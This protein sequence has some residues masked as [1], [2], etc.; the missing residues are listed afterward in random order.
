VDT[1][2]E[3]NPSA[4]T[5]NVHVSVSG[6][7]RLNV[8]VVDATGRI[9]RHLLDGPHP[10][11][12]YSLTWDGRDDESRELPAGVYFTHVVTAKGTTTGRVVLAR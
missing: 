5:C 1:S 6:N 10:A 9:I 3:P 7:G 4:G 11:G 2:I 8:D 12:D